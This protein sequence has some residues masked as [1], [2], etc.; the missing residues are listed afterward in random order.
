MKEISFIIPVYNA[1]KYIE[2]CLKNLLDYKGENVEFIIIN[3]GSNDDSDEILKR[4]KKADNKKKYIN[5]SNTGV[6]NSRNMGI[7]KATGEY[8][9]FID[10]DDYLEKNTV[11]NLLQIINNNHE[12]LYI[13]PYYI[14]ENGK[15]MKVNYSSINRKYDTK[16]KIVELIPNLIGNVDEKGNRIQN[17]MGSIWSKVFKSKIIKNNHI[18]MNENIE[19]TEDLN[20]VIEYIVHCN[21]LKIVDYYYY[22]YV[23]E[24]NQSI[25]KKYKANLYN[26]LELSLKNISEILK[27]NG[28][29]LDNVIKYKMFYNIYASLVNECKNDTNLKNK[30]KN[31]LKFS[32]ILKRDKKY[33]K[34]LSKKEKIIKFFLEKQ[35]IMPLIIYY[36]KSI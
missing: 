29:F 5:K 33:I 27:N 2:R 8:I 31:I 6:S 11:Y 20:F 15:K 7:A 12:D 24:N 35:W 13:M 4:Y 25:T 3:D 18:V 23:M 21:N 28:I 34:G 17:I 36:S 30:R 16:E 9:V 10:I 26:Q 14:V 1:S 22:N 32:N 19:I